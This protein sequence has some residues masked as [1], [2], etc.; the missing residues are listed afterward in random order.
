MRI[1]ESRQLCDV[2]QKYDYTSRLGRDRWAWEFC[3]RDPELREKSR[4]SGS[5]DHVAGRPTACPGVTFLKLRCPQP[6]AE[7][8]GLCFFPDTDAGGVAADVFWSAQQYPRDISVHVVEAGEADVDEYQMLALQ[9]CGIT[10]LT[11]YDGSEQVIL[12]GAGCAVQVMVKGM[13]LL[14]SQPHKMVLT[15]E[16]DECI[17]AKTDVLKKA[18]VSRSRQKGSDQT[19][20]G[21]Q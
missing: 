14:S 19:Y 2:V 8:Y 21:C 16:G 12:R 18:Q 10:H 13:S 5:G 15:I 6:E 3:R 4:F 11:C 20:S 9:R 1:Y 7:V 17:D